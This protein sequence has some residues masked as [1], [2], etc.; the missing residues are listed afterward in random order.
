MQKV[1]GGEFGINEELLKE[2][3]G[4][5]LDIP[6]SSGR[7]AL[8][9]IL[10]SEN[11]LTGGHTIL[12]PNY[13]CDSVVRTVKEAGWNY[14]FYSVKDNLEFNDE[15]ILNYPHIAAVLVINYFGIID[16]KT[17][18]R[19]IKELRPDIIII[20]DDVQA[21]FEY[22]KSE[23]DYSFTSLRKW[24]PC[25]DGALINTKR[26]LKRDSIDSCKWSQ[27]KL[28]GN[29]LKQYDYLVDDSICLELLK[30]GED[31][32]D[33][34]FHSKCSNASNLIFCNTNLDEVSGRRKKN[35]EFLH[36]E[37]LKLNVKHV[38]RKD[39]V[40]LFIPIYIE[41][42]NSLRKEF[43]ANS[44]FTPV[45]WPRISDELN[46][47]NDIYDI[48][49]SLICDQRYELDDMRRQIEVLHKFLR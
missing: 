18:I 49:L 41:N 34:N 4:D 5:K 9:T 1:M 30:K 28:A 42:R 22:K 24:F 39:S 40:P 6:Y 48:E 3:T 32:L 44:I 46:G 33:I 19:N 37:L 7:H 21:F 23:A 29:I 8:F 25:P 45:H 14:V 2:V 16:L 10:N 26:K 43:F 31:L 17:K 20:E 47:M 12:I 27:Y 11:S 38:Y 15:E 13:I 35:A 36:E